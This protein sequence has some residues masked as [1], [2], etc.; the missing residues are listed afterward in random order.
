VYSPTVVERRL[1]AARKAGLT[2]QRLPRERSIEIA[3]KL[4]RLRYGKDGRLLPDNGLVRPIDDKERAFIESERLLCK[5]DFHYFFT[6]YYKLQLDPGV[7]DPGGALGTTESINEGQVEKIGPPVLLES[8]HR[9]ITLIGRREEECFQE[10][11]KHKFTT[12][13]L[14]VFHKVRQVAATATA[15]A[16]SLHRMLF[17]PGTR[18]F[19]ASVDAAR[20]SELF[21]RDHLSLDNLPFWLKPPIYPDKQD[22]EL[23][24]AH[25]ISSSC[26]YQAENQQAGGIGV[27][28]QQD[29]AHLTE[30]ALWQYPGR[31]KFSFLPALPKA[32]TTMLIMESTSD[33]KGNFWHE[34]S[35]GVRHHREGYESWVY[36]FIPWW[37]NK[38]KYRDIPPVGWQPKQHTLN[39]AEMIER[40]SPEFNDGVSYRPSI[41]QLYW[42][43]MERAR[44]VAQGELA[45]FLTNYPATPEQSF[46]AHSRGALP[47]EMIEE[48]ET[49]TMMPGSSYELF[50]AAQSV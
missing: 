15:R 50:L 41:E 1:S 11:R 47:T 18:S 9:Y 30:V 13:I 22:V 23:G 39:H 48:M 27:G 43:Q 6:R 28:T 12:G 38:L 26:V 17:W 21:K 37:Y 10:Y 49:E 34:L 35:E 16:V 42:W 45:S 40:T 31:I 7:L 20:V 33:G 46:Q 14:A 4:E 8:Q 5:M 32:M 3:S 2:F 19:T 24:F 36:A 44:H 29:I 25:P